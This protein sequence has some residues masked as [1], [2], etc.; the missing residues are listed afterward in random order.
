[1]KYIAMTTP[2]FCPDIIEYIKGRDELCI[3]VLSACRKQVIGNTQSLHL[4]T[5]LFTELN[6]AVAEMVVYKN[7]FADPTILPDF[8]IIPSN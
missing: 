1:M 3:I 5:K 7:K 4:Q 2:I 6:F 8:Y